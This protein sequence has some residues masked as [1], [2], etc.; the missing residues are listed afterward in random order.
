ML[1][2]S[3]P[4]AVVYPGRLLQEMRVYTGGS[5]DLFF[6]RVFNGRLIAKSPR[7]ITPGP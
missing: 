3:S 5:D 4:F 2:F 1:V 6:F 7:T